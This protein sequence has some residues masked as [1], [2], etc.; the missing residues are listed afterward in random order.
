M[1]ALTSR[2]LNDASNSSKSFDTF[3]GDFPRILSELLQS[4]HPF[5]PAHLRPEL[6]IG[7]RLFLE[8]RPLP[9]PQLLHGSLSLQR[10]DPRPQPDQP[11][12]DGVQL[13][14]GRGQVVAFGADEAGV[15]GDRLVDAAE[16]AFDLAVE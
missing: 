10:F 16:A 4:F 3:A 1:R 14:A 12:G 2:E 5:P 9:D 13:P 6:P 8:G 11:L 7:F 15:G